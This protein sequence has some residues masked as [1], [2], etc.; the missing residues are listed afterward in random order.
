MTPAPVTVSLILDRLHAINGLLG[1]PYKT[2][3]YFP[4]TVQTA[5]MPLLVPVFGANQRSSTNSN[6]KRNTRNYTLVGFVGE[7]M[8]GLADGERTKDC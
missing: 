8:Q 5:Q 2:R 4:N 6:Y 7:F 3:R 1:S